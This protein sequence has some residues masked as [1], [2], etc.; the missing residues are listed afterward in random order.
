MKESGIAIDARMYQSSGIGT[1]LRGL[2][3][4]LQ[5]LDTTEFPI[6]LLG[7]PAILPQSGWPIANAHSSI[8]SV[9]EQFEI[10]Y[11]LHKTKTK[12]LHSVHY[13]MPLL[14]PSHTVV[15]VHDLI[16][17]KF[18]QYWPSPIARAYA[19][20]FFFHII[21]RAGAILTVSEHTKR[22]LIELLAIPAERI[23]VTYNAVDHN[24]FATRDAQGR[25]ALDRMGLPKDYFLYIGNLKEF[26]NVQRLVESYKQLK[27]Q[28]RDIPSLV[29]VGRNFIPGFESLLSDT[30]GVQWIGEIDHERLPALYQHAMA[31]LFPSLYEGFG[32]PPLEAMASGTPVMCSNRASLPEVVGDAALMVDPEN[33]EA[34]MAAM[35]RLIDDASLRSELSAKGLK[36]AATFSWDRL[37]A[38]TLAVYKRC[39]S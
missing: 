13:N 8:Y 26:K 2:I 3:Q 16:H 31:F 33:S 38:Q 20:F 22:D 30:S 12:W 7:N 14:N 1:Y 6:R 10:P 24:R 4:G 18:P 35:T 19:H 32:L 11:K 17:L 27:A 5:N 37:A 29:M 9:R 23:T 34:M 39:L 21:P 25:S 28:R 15:T 36:R